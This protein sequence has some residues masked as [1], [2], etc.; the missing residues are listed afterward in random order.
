MKQE[1]E[2]FVPRVEFA[3]LV[4]MKAGEKMK[5]TAGEEKMRSQQ[6]AGVGQELTRKAKLLQNDTAASGTSYLHRPPFKHL[7][8][9][10]VMCL[11]NINNQIGLEMFYKHIV[12]YWDNLDRSF[13]QISQ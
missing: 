13:P 11:I 3:S 6:P 4:D 7:A 9:I 1:T 8:W 5:T 10:Q 12:Y 2:C